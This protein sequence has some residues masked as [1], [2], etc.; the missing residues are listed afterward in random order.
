M[1]VCTCTCNVHVYVPPTCQHALPW[2]RI[3][4]ARWD[5]LKAVVK[6]GF[7]IIMSLSYLLELEGVK[8]YIILSRKEITPPHIPQAFTA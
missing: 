5:G 4:R 3:C 2:V 7:G 8:G 1:Y 6:G